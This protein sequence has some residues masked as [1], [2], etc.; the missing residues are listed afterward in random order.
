MQAE[1][2]VDGYHLD[3]VHASYLELAGMR[4]KEAAQSAGGDNVKAIR[5][6]NPDTSG[7]NYSLG[8]GHVMI[9]INLPNFRDRGLGMLYDAL[10]ERVG[11]GK[12]KWTAARLRQV[13]IYPNVILFDG[14]STQ[15]RHWRRS[16]PMKPKSRRIPSLRWEN[17]LRR[18]AAGFASTKT[19]TARAD[20]PPRATSLNL[21]PVRPVTRVLNRPGK[22]LTAA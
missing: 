21:M 16:V 10:V 6:T 7:G 3:I 17:H 12:A 20:W 13:L 4:A 18:D 11:E 2:G 15:M 14:I 22:T 1:N 19:S 8:N 9:G 5:P